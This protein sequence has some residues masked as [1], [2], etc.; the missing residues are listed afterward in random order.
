M[1]YQCEPARQ[2]QRAN[3]TRSTV[4]KFLSYRSPMV[5]V[6]STRSPM[7]SQREASKRVQMA[8]KSDDAYFVTRGGL[9]APYALA[10]R[11]RSVELFAALRQHAATIS[12]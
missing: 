4:V 1:E 7:V 5:E 12:G 10:S 11:L 3:N 8:G 9:G 2:V 6:L